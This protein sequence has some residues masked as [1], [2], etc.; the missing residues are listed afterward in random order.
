MF[1]IPAAISRVTSCHGDDN[2]STTDAVPDMTSATAPSGEVTRSSIASATYEAWNAFSADD[3][4][5]WA[6]NPPVPQWI[7]YEFPVAV[8]INKY[9]VKSNAAHYPHDW[10]LEGSNNDADWDVLSD[11]T[12]NS[13]VEGWFTFLGEL[14]YKYYRITVTASEGDRGVFFDIILVE[15]QC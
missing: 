3:A 14:A 7:K 2:P 9:F 4:V 8:N 12:G 15:S 5:E 6:S 10:V 13:L 1:S 11:I